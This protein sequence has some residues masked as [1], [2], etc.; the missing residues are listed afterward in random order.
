VPHAKGLRAAGVLPGIDLRWHGA[1]GRLEYDFVLAPHADPAAIELHASE[2]LHIDDRGQ[3]LQGTGPDALVHE[4]PVA[5]QE[6]HGTRRP[7]DVAF[8]IVAA[9]CFGFPLGSYDPALPL[10]IDPVLAFGTYIGGS[11][12]DIVRDCELDANGDAVICGDTWSLDFPLLGGGQ[13]PLGGSQDAFAAKID[14]NGALLWST[15][16]GGGGSDSISGFGL[17]LDGAGR[18]YLSGQT[19]SLD[20][21]VTPRA[22]Q[23]AYGGGSTDGYVVRLTPSGQLDYA[24]YVGGPDGDALRGIDVRHDANLGDIA[25]VTGSASAGFPTT[26]NAYS[27][28]NAG[29]TD[30][31]LVCMLPLGGGPSDLLYSS[32][33]G[34][35]WYEMGW[36]VAVDA[37]GFAH[38]SGVAVQSGV[39]ARFPTTPNAFHTGATPSRKQTIFTHFYACMDPLGVGPQ[40]R[41]SVILENGNAVNQGSGD[42]AVDG[43]GRA[44][45]CGSTADSSYPTK[46][47]FQPSFGGMQDAFLTVIDP[48]LSGAASLV[49]STFLGGSGTDYAMGVGVAGG[50]V[51]VG[52]ENQ[53]SGGKR[54]KLFP[55]TTDAI[56]R[57]N[58]GNWDAFVTVFDPSLAGAA[59]RVYST[60][61]GGT[62]LDETRCLSVSASGSILIGGVTG[63][64]D[65]LAGRPTGFDASPNGSF[66]GWLF[67]ID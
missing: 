42:V 8:R 37:S 15:Y 26:P 20:I 48:S 10:V 60:L 9:D 22:F 43:A 23:T 7:V 2:P 30:V 32:F 64:T 63:S 38:L 62:G 59:S 39:T 3:L 29:N 16:V 31:V 44:Y 11:G 47:A 33:L 34:G 17:A 4:A 6:H 58:A 67:R 14:A 46:N 50:L 27:T 41:Y 66:D 45:V 61:L 49:Y 65:L 19:Q 52:G 40:L 51:Y 55:T 28:T 56:Q 18:V 53:E 25:Y 57:T 21:P 24:T 35:G 54:P 1:R 36:G 12:I 5:W 13:G